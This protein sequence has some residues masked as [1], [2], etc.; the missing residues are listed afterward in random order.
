MKSTL[1]LLLL[2]SGCA[3]APQTHQSLDARHTAGIIGIDVDGNMRVFIFVSKTG[4]TLPVE[5]DECAASQ[6]CH[7]LVQRF[8]GQKKTM[9]LSLHGTPVE[10]AQYLPHRSLH[11]IDVQGHLPLLAAHTDSCR[12]PQFVFD[13]EGHP[14]FLLCFRE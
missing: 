8:S 14:L 12:M 13:D 6:P 3:A 9:L 2:L 11:E 5:A 4:R 1:A 10:D 7:E